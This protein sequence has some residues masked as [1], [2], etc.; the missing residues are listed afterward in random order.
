MT[1]D[2]P[3]A[4]P[5]S[6]SP[7]D[8][9]ADGAAG[10]TIPAAKAHGPYS[11]A[12][13]RSAYETTRKLLIAANLDWPMLHGGAPKAYEHLLV[14]PERKQFLAGLHLTAL[15]QNG[16]PKNTRRE[17]SS[18]APGRTSFV[19]TVVKVH[20]TMKAGLTINSGSEV[21]RIRYDYLFVYAVEPP[22]NPASWMRAVQQQYGTV[23]FGRW[24]YSGSSFE[25]WISDGN[26]TAG[27]DFR[28]RDGYIHPAYPLAAPAAIRSRAPEAPTP[29]QAAASAVSSA[30]RSRRS[31]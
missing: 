27:I 11:A 3:P 26:S 13:V 22:G 30:Q 24:D 12:Q 31:P 16:W 14:E 18:F 17:V 20:G 7:G 23:D 4:D 8:H 2:G 10:I 9:W 19:T 21:L 1:A 6:G 28:T 29:A 15:D 25:P 5:F